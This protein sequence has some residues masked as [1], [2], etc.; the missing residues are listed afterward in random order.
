VKI[1]QQTQLIFLLAGI[2]LLF[3]LHQDVIYDSD[4][5]AYLSGAKNLLENGRY[6]VNGKPDWRGVGYGHFLAIPFFLFGANF[7]SGVFLSIFCALATLI[8]VFKI[9]KFQF[10][11]PHSV[12]VLLVLFP[13]FHFWRQSTT[14]MT[15]IPALN[16]LCWGFYFLLQFYQHW[17]RTSFY[18]ACVFLGVAI[19]FRPVNIFVGIFFIPIFFQK[20]YWGDLILGALVVSLLLIPQL[21]YNSTYFGGPFVSGYS[22]IFKPF[23]WTYF[24]KADEVLRRPAFQLGHYFRNVLLKP[25]GLLTWL[26]F[27][28]F[29]LVAGIRKMQSSRLL[30]LL[31]AWLGSYLL[32]ISFYAYHDERFFVPLLPPLAIFTVLGFQQITRW[33]HRKNFKKLAFYHPKPLHLFF[34]CWIPGFLLNWTLIQTSINLHANR[35]AA[36]AWVKKTAP[37]NAGLI[38]SEAYLGRFL[39]GLETI[40][41]SKTWNQQADFSTMAEFIQQKKPVFVVLPQNRLYVVTAMNATSGYEDIQAWLAENFAPDSLAV[42][43]SELPWLLNWDDLARTLHS[44]KSLEWPQERFYVWKIA[45][46]IKNNSN[47][48]DTDKVGSIGI[49]QN[50]REFYTG[51]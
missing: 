49:Q 45:P 46:Q 44:V 14:L 6:F 38:T 1:N 24:F 12:L 39:T 48:P 3:L 27:L 21:I 19:L 8:A 9:S 22:Q 31:G 18:S 35:Y 34:L 20:K 32:I 13:S 26:P 25:T 15:E 33:L 17:K 47:P 28:I 4:Q 16:F 40:N 43:T 50:T 41:S 7:Q 11:W 30:R 5:I 23:D 42:F 37:E 51:N 10:D 2:L 29:G 36:L